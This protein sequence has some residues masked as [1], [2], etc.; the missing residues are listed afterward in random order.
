MN[1]VNNGA[2]LRFYMFMFYA[3][4]LWYNSKKETSKKNCT[5]FISYKN[6]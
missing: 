3:K 6:N 5:K 2:V 1:D 4:Y